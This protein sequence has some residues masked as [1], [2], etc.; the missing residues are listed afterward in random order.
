MTQA[1]KDGLKIENIQAEDLKVR[2]GLIENSENVVRP[3][4]LPI[5]SDLSKEIKL[6]IDYY[7]TIFKQKID[8]VSIIGGSAL[9]PAI[10]DVLKVNINREVKIA[11]SGYDIDLGSITGKSNPFPLFANVIGLGMLGSSG[12]FKDMNLL[13]KMPKSEINSVNKFDLFNLGY[14]SKI[15]TI[16]IIVDN[17]YV[18]VVLVI[19][20]I[21]ILFI[22][23]QL[24][25]SLRFDMYSSIFSF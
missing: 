19:L 15:N 25:R 16:R 3:I 10:A 13:K 12:Q 14:L 6:A 5:I 11:I 1:I 20:I 24:V 17:K 2:F 18:L 8:D 9:L 23:L 21:V 7:E 22:L 4:I